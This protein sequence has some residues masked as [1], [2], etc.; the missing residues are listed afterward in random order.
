MVA[1]GWLNDLVPQWGMFS[2]S[3]ELLCKGKDWAED[4]LFYLRERGNGIEKVNLELQ[5]ACKQECTIFVGKKVVTVPIKNSMLK[6]CV[7]VCQALLDITVINVYLF[8]LHA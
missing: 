4:P 8:N 1:E 7:T 3:H 5:T 6:N 2:A